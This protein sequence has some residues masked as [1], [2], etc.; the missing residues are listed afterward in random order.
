MSTANSAVDRWPSLSRDGCFWGMTATQLLGAFNDNL[1]KQL[2]LLYCLSVV[3]QQGGN[4]QPV[5]FF[6]FSIPFVLGSGFSGFLA[7]RYSKRTLIIACKFGEIAVMLA[8]VVAIAPKRRAVAEGV[9]A[10]S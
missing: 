6:L 7:D 3:G 9:A 10:A 4:Y 1:F 2:V 8:G 5:A